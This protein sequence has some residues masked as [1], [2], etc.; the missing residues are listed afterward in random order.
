MRTNIIVA[1][2]L[3]RAIGY[4]DSLPWRGR[5]PEDMHRFRQLTTGHTVVMGRKTF[6]SI[7]RALPERRNIVISRDDQLKL[8]GVELV[9]S[10]DAALESAA[11]EE[12]LFIIGGGTVYALALNVADRLY[13]T[14][15][16]HEFAGDTFFVE[17]DLDQWQL[18]GYER[19]MADDDNEFSMEFMT[20]DRI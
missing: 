19:Y 14:R 4:Q 7:G 1:H 20:Y 8:E 12:E 17:I 2:D 11:S 10:F 16:E 3:N 9:S 6:D 18:T 13:V 5:L 15:I